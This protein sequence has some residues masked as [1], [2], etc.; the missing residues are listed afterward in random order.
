[1]KKTLVTG[2]TGLVGSQ[3]KGNKYQKISSKDLNLLDQKSISDYLEENSNVKSIIHCAARVGGVK[4]N[5]DYPAEFTYE[6]LKMN[7]GIIEEARNAG[8]KNLVCFSSTCVFPDKVEYPLSPDKIHLGPPHPSN[9]GYA[10]AKRMADIQIQSY[11]EQYGLNYFTVIPCNIYGPNDN[12]SLQDGHVVPSLIHKFYLAKQ[13]NEDVTIWGSGSPLRE[14]IYSEDVAKLVEILLETY[15]G[16]APVILSTGNE[17]T[18]KDLVNLIADIYEFKGNIIWDISKP[19]GQYRKPSDNSVI[20]SIAPDFKFT[21]IEEG[22]IKS[23]E[24]FID[25]YP[26]IRK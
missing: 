25:N 12:Y 1:M 10:Y 13:N 7:T 17:I 22:L 18:I 16:S 24:W 6:N 11:R 5:I 3:F 4:A 26:N 21:P 20:K 23:I 15:T 19:E 8:I 14:F 2:G 9:Y